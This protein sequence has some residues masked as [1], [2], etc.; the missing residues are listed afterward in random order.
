[1]PGTRTDNPHDPAFHD[2]AAYVEAVLAVVERIPS[3]RVMSY[4]AIADFLHERYG[5]SSAR[6][7]GTPARRSRS[8]SLGGSISTNRT[9]GRS[10]KDFFS[11]GMAT[12]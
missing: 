3:G 11:N 5:R 8:G 12:L 7:V 2:P 9:A 1:M 10:G 4:G 6:R